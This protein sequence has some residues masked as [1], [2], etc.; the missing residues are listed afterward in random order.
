MLV[1]E[2]GRY[3][4]AFEAT[5]E[6]ARSNGMP[7]VLRDRRG[8][9]VETEPAHAPTLMEPWHGDGATLGTRFE[10]TLGTQRR[11]ARFEFTPAGFSPPSEGT[12][13]PLAGPDLLAAAT[14]VTDLTLHDGEMELRVWVYVERANYPGLRRSTWTRGKPTVTRIIEPDGNGEGEPVPSQFWTPVARDR[15]FERR[16]LA[17]V[18]NTLLTVQE[19]N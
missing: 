14:R 4:A 10:N 6:A 5:V 17:S 16:L 1:I 7:A 19:S 9:V 12:T 18:S 8:G 2:Q 3:Q 13:E 15:D 11:I